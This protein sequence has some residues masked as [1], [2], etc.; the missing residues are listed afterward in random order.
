[1][2]KYLLMLFSVL[3]TVSLLGCSSSNTI[4]ERK[5]ITAKNI[6]TTKVSS[7]KWTNKTY[8]SIG[9][10]I[11]WQ[12]KQKYPDSKKVATGYQSL[13]DEKIGFKAFLNYSIVGASMAKSSTYPTKHSIMFSFINKNY[14]HTDMITILAGTNDFK[15]NVPLGEISKKGDKNFDETTF[16]GSYTKLLDYILKQNQWI[17]IYLFTPLQRDN[18]GYDINKINSAG[19]KLI[20]YVNAVKKIGEL[21]NLPVLDL[22]SV[23]GIDLSNIKQYTRD[24]LHPND[25]G[26]KLISKPIFDFIENN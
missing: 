23:S 25:L 24:G 4:V 21:Y 7:A 15:L 6:V 26:Y 18:G 12:D 8:I 5:A 17:K 19:F 20:D 22:Y 2:K 11:S 14:L 10:S 16:Y 13:L 9:D 1:V 3:L